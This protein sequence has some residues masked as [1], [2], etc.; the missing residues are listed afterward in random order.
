MKAAEIT[1]KDS[2]LSFPEQ[3]ILKDIVRKIPSRYPMINKILLYGSKA[4]GDFTEESDIDIL[5]TTDYSL[6]RA[7]KFEISDIIFELEVKYST[8]I[9]VIFVSGT[10]FKTKTT[11]FI[12]RIKSEGIILWSRG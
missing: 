6:P 11:P 2:R 5:F 8:V 3:R 7:L 9:S 12:K 10:D 4:R 1:D